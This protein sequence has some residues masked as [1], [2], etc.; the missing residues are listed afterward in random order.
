MGQGVGNVPRWSNPFSISAGLSL[1][2]WTV[3]RF[4]QG[5]SLL[6]SSIQSVINTDTYSVPDPPGLVPG[7]EVD[8]APGSWPCGPDTLVLL[9]EIWDEANPSDSLENPQGPPILKPKGSHHPEPCFPADLP[10]L[11][12]GPPLP[13]FS[14]TPSLG[15]LLSSMILTL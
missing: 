9:P 14:P 8:K 2:C 1:P 4:H 13:R 15:P 11:L 10:I 6:R 3:L 7:T 5:L 12:R